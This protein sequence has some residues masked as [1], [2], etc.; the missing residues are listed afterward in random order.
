MKQTF[1]YLI[2][3]QFIF[4]SNKYSHNHRCIMYEINITK[5]VMELKI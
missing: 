2:V 4:F 5:D 3:F 1:V